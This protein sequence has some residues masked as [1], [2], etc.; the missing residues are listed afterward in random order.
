MEERVL[1]GHGRASRSVS[2]SRLRVDALSRSLLPLR[3]TTCVCVWVCM[4]A[5]KM[6][7]VHTAI[8]QNGKDGVMMDG[9]PLHEVPA[10]AL[11]ILTLPKAL[12]P[13]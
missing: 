7:V 8:A 1:R 6:S 11:Q 4:R 10:P 5:C 3:L 12:N 2:T 13:P 9:I